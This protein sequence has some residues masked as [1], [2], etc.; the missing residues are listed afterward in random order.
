MLQ[1]TKNKYF[2]TNLK[3]TF[4]FFSVTGLYLLGLAENSCQEWRTLAEKDFLNNFLLYFKSLISIV[5]TIACK[6]KFYEDPLS[7]S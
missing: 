5:E 7:M 2:Y 6:F 3:F 1:L 4:I